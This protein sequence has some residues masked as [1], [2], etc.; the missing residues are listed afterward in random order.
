MTMPVYVAAPWEDGA[1]V[2]MMV[3]S[4]LVERGLVPTSTWCETADGAKEDFTRLTRAAKAAAAQRNDHDIH[5]AEVVLV[6]ARPGAGGEM[7]AE[8][9]YALALGKRVVWVGREILSASRDGVMRV[10]NVED[11]FAVL[12]N[13]ARASA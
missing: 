1:I 9:R 11:A 6:L 3:H 7:F 5:R 13:M 10:D 12:E 4:A 8:A 2:R